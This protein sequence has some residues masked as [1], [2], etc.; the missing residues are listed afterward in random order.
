MAAPP[1]S[2]HVSRTS[3]VSW[4][5]TIARVAGV[6]QVGWNTREFAPGTAGSGDT[7]GGGVEAELTALAMSGATTLV[8]LMA[9]DAWATARS[10]A[11]ALFGRGRADEARAADAELEEARAAVVAAADSGD[12]AALAEIESRWQARLLLLLRED[13]AA[14]AGLRALM[15]AAEHSTEPGTSV[16]NTISGGDIRG[17]VIQTGTIEGDLHFG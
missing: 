16:H 3:A 11:R 6:L 1:G 15:A 2:P 14:Q 13:P 17:P 4:P 12:R 7:K 8:Q 5:S 10:R 9:G